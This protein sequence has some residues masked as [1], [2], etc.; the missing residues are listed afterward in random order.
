MEFGS[1]FVYLQ[2]EDDDADVI[3]LEEGLKK[4]SLDD[5]KKNDED[6]DVCMLDILDTAGQEEFSTI[7][8][9]YMRLGQAFVIV[10]SIDDKNSFQAALDIHTLAKRIKGTSFS[11]ILCGNKLDLESERQVPAA[12]GEKEAKA[13][14]MAFMETSAKTGEKV[15]LAFEELIRRTIRTGI[16]YRIAIL[17]SG[18][19]GKSAIVIRLTQDT[20]LNDYDPT[21]EESFRT[22]ITV[23]GIPKDKIQLSEDQPPRVSPS[24]V[25]SRRRSAKIKSHKTR[26]ADGNVILVSLGTLE[27]DPKIMTGDAVS[28]CK[29]PAILSHVSTITPSS[30]GDT[31]SQTWM[32]D[33]CDTKNEVDVSD[34]E[35]PKESQVDFLV[36][37]SSERETEVTLETDKPVSQAG[38]VIY[39]ID[40]SSS[41]GIKT[42]L[43]KLQAEWFALRRGTVASVSR[44]DCIK[45]AVQRQID[46]H[47]IE[48]PEKKAGLVSFG[49]V[50]KFM[51]DKD[52]K[53]EFTSAASYLDRLLTLGK[54]LAVTETMKPLSENAEALRGQISNLR[55]AGSTA[56]GPALAMCVGFLSKTPGS[57]IVLCTDGEPN[58]GIG[59]LPGDPGFYD[60]I[61]EIAQEQQ[62]TISV[63][64]IQTCKEYELETVSKAAAITGGTI[65]LL[66]PHELSHK[67]RELMQDVIIATGVEVTAILH[68]YLCFVSE[69]I[70][71][72]K[73]SIASCS[74]GN[75]HKSTELTF[76]FQKKEEFQNAEV[77]ALPFQ[78]L[79]IP[80]VGAMAMKESAAKAKAGNVLGAR[81][82]LKSHHLMSV[83]SATRDYDK[84]NEFLSFERNALE[85]E[86]ELMVPLAAAPSLRAANLHKVG[87]ERRAARMKGK[88]GMR[89]RV[90]AKCKLTSSQHQEKFYKYEGN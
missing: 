49:S 71:F 86:G 84:G 57:E 63:I 7:R 28:C 32:C 35:I 53:V 50:I 3:M 17:G 70:E 78:N 25:P 4:A 66:S 58:Q 22:T 27:N 73:K 77:S 6:G 55:L 20:F 21:I 45:Q 88:E 33:F 26:R 23:K 13:R 19:V 62:T 65:N 69:K 16:E 10:Y 82:H 54:S 60:K 24:K 76:R 68:P 2:G 44:L 36:E 29:C 75:V 12:D 8:E 74:L 34:E 14:D 72:N 39:C 52:T 80:V 11:A 41:M 43:P 31:S 47:E 40:V 9:Q 61:G 85:L 89:T 30:S 56:L 18:G 38:V 1:K 83:A 79:N 64:G 42:A 5:L 48:S 51:C 81:L 46:F 15:T 87:Q 59:S 67:M 37:A 90:I